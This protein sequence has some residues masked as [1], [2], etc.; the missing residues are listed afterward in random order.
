[1]SGGGWY[2]GGSGGNGGYAMGAAIYIGG[3]IEDGAYDVRE[4]KIVGSTFSGNTAVGGSGGLG[5]NEGVDGDDGPASPVY[6]GHTG[7]G[8]AHDI[9]S[10]AWIGI[11]SISSDKS[12]YI[13]N[14]YYT[15]SGPHPDYSTVSVSTSDVPAD[16]TSSSTITVT[17]LDIGGNPVY[18]DAV[19][20]A[21]GDGS[22]VISPAS[23]VTDFSGVATFTVTDLHA[24]TVVYT[25]K[26][27]SSD[28]TLAPKAT[29]TFHPGPTSASASTVT[30]DT[31]HVVANGMD[32]CTITVT[33]KDVLGNPAGSGKTVT[34]TAGSGS[35][36]ISP[37]STTTDVSGRAVFYVS[38]N[39]AQTVTYTARNTTEDVTVT[40]TVTVVYSQYDWIVNTLT[41][42]NTVGTLR[43][44]M[45]S[46]PSGTT[47]TFAPDLAGGTLSLNSTLPAI[48]RDLTIN[49]FGT[50]ITIS[51]MDLY[52]VSVI[53]S[54]TV[55]I[56]GI[57]ISNG[58]QYGIN[59]VDMPDDNTDPE[60]Y[61]QGIYGGGLLV[62]GGTIYMD[63]V[64]FLN[65]SAFGGN[66]GNG[67]ST[68]SWAGRGGSGGYGYGGAIYF[69]G[70]S[71]TITNSAFSNNSAN[72]GSGGNGADC[73]GNY[74]GD[75]GNGGDGHGGAF[76]INSGSVTVI[77]STFTDNSANGGSGGNGGTG[78]S[79]AVGGENGGDGGNSFG[80]TIFV[81]TGDLAISNSQFS[82]N[83]ATGG[84][85]GTGNK[86]N[87]TPGNSDGLSIYSESSAVLASNV[88]FDPGPLGFYVPSTSDAALSTVI[89]SPASVSSDGT[90]FSTIT[91][92]L[93][94]S[95]GGSAGSG[96]TVVLSA[97]S[98]TSVI[99]P[100][101]AVTDGS[102]RAVFTVTDNIAE[103]VTYTARD[104]THN[105]T[106][107][108]TATVA[109]LRPE[110]GRSTVT[111]SNDAVTANGTE[112][113]SI[114][115]ILN[116]A[117][118]AP[119][120]NKTVTLDQG[121][122]HSVIS[123]SSAVTDAS[124]KAVF[125]VKNSYEEIVIYTAVDT[126]DNLTVN[127]TGAVTYTAYA[128]VV[129]NLS[130]ADELGTLRYAVGNA[131]N[132]ASITF[133]PGLDGIIELTGPLPA[134]SRDLT[135]DGSG[136]GISV[137]GNGLHRVFEIGSGTVTFKDISIIDGK[138]TGAD[139]AGVDAAFTPGGNGEDASGAG[140]MISNGTVYIENVAFLD[141]SVTGGN[142]GRSADV[143]S[144]IA[145]QDG[146][147]GG[148]AYGGAIHLDDGS[149]TITGSSFNGNSVV[150]GDGGDG[151]DGGIGGDG[152]S[153]GNAYGG[154]IH[155]DNGSLTVTNCIFAGS[156]ATYGSGGA[157][158]NTLNSGFS[159]HNG[160]N[161]SARGV[162]IYSQGG[163]VALS[164][165]T[166]SS[167]ISNYY[168]ALPT[169]DSRSTVTAS[170][171]SVGSDG[172][173]SSTITVA[174]QDTNGSSVGAGHVVAL[175]AGSGS[176]TISPA[177]YTTGYDGIAIFN[178]TDIRGETVSY[179]A[180]DSTSNVTLSQTATV[181][182]LL[183]DA[184]LSTVAADPVV[185]YSND[186][187]ST[188][189]VTLM[190]AN[191]EPAANKAVTLA[192]G[193]GSSTI[194]P[195]SAVTDANGTAT[196]TVTGINPETVTYTATCTTDNLTVTQTA[197]VTFPPADAAQSTVTASPTTASFASNNSSVIT[198]GL[199]YA[200]GNPAANK[201]VTLAAES[202]SS[203][204][205]PSSTVTDANGT[206]TFTVANT[207]AEDVTYTVIDT[208]DSVTLTQ[209]VTVVFDVH[210][211]TVDSLEDTNSP[212]TLRYALSTV[213]EGS[214][215]TFQAG[216]TG[217]IALQTQLPA[218]DR[219][220]AIDGAGAGISISGN[221]LHRVFEVTDGTVSMKNLT[222][223]NGAMVGS[224]G[225]NAAY[226]EKAGAGAAGEGAGL[227]ITD[228]AVSLDNVSFS[229]NRVV[230]GNGG[231]G[232]GNL[233]GGTGGSGAGGAIYVSAGTLTLNNCRFEGNQA[234]GGNAG[235]G[236]VFD[237]WNGVRSGPRTKGASGGGGYGGAVYIS[238]GTLTI[239]DCTFVGNQTT[240][241]IGGNA[242][243]YILAGVAGPAEPGTAALFIQMLAH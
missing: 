235:N 180:V 221:H 39:A 138:A 12:E 54:G 78:A 18:G 71:T 2:F 29:V 76:F 237:T 48:N 136:A 46:A 188:V 154:A 215:I 146:G 189:T 223:A 86:S 27:T 131:P 155:N 38:S 106:V 160:S 99:S 31:T 47:I 72:G 165:L 157:K 186:N 104:T 193:S 57:T 3:D 95:N 59:G 101:S 185:T 148:S 116:Y 226:P 174:L 112:E 228:G 69:N 195:A 58:H 124:G 20:L 42:S 67:G 117:D 206:A 119:A 15:L 232:Q 21:P 82:G 144:G 231:L 127:Q 14:S 229:N 89:A 61:G 79:Y 230:G 128:W 121:S 49:G 107:E 170:P 102:G 236:G 147:S 194:S 182:Y 179:T 36:D 111:V 234:T 73:A 84:I 162:D 40:Q 56:K 151:G 225:P 30:A 134:I 141:N 177:S 87:G 129:T 168:N 80:G 122:G 6:T 68:Y 37:T 94:G 242:G 53:D 81:N 93:N 133:Q 217:T 190:Y 64:T 17:L 44:A 192:A 207:K 198:V 173:T 167:G 171:E 109:F 130:D 35:S 243:R 92:T 45:A 28:T 209:T 98:G 158:G 176:S 224:D 33:M 220:L 184:G 213:G 8:Y 24:E 108:Q 74:G 178:V 210:T 62:N 105:V 183:P 7:E 1:M 159:S 205:S 214:L 211:V 204:I 65:N 139:G 145:A 200:N 212:G 4:V 41:D 43:Y 70:G 202:G 113:S 75:G 25:V 114:T 77:D 238:T 97:G 156:S 140:L 181:E 10:N 96:K 233:H 216:L 203:T 90:T 126:N 66:G 91:V 152:G 120:A 51:G 222:I 208:T 218:I 125:T 110:A 163:L 60:A 149:L 132:E 32:R 175:T 161:G 153:G 219:D 239:A 50:D 118:G 5:G 19:I 26:D 240:G 201:T 150:G 55:S 16:G 169:N 23:A 191:G 115:V 137:S 52:R 13:N 100:S 85:R 11:R 22:S 241:G 166:L 88:G 196:F 164:N 142:G 9:Y 103:T 63:H 135:I 143:S 172:V 197:A 187:S 199:R 227:L 34:L 83:S 123:P